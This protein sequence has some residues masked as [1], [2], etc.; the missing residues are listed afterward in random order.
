MLPQQGSNLHHE[1]QNLVS[2][3]LD[4]RVIIIFVVPPG[5]EPGSKAVF[6]YGAKTRCSA[7]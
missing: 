2:C 7:S 4:D 3:Q 6:R 1:S 5:F